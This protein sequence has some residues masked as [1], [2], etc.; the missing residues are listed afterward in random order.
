MGLTLE[1]KD[2]LRKEIEQ[3]LKALAGELRGDAERVGQE[4]YGELAGATH[5]SGDESVADL[6]A[7]LGQA[8]LTRDLAEQRELQAAAQRIAEDSYG[9]CADCGV[10]IPF[11]RLQANPGALRCLPCQGRYEKTHGQKAGP[12]L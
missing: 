7:D 12:S 4:P 1:Q 5:D 9:A 2:V 8:D 11:A 6:V 3:R 10:D